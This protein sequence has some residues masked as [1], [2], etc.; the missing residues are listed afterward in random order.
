MAVPN[1]ALR[2]DAVRNRDLL[3]AAAEQEFAE[4]G[5]DAS[6]ADITARAEL[7]K[8]TFFRHF[9]TKEDLIAAIV[10]GH[11][12]AL[13]AVGQRLLAAP[14]AGEALLEF[15]TEAADQRQQREVAFLIRASESNPTMSEL[16]EAFFAT[17]NAL[18][19][20]AQ[21]ARAVRDDITGTDVVLLMCAPSSIVEHMPGAAP[22]LW[23]RYLAM[24]FDGLRPEGAHPLPS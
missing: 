19:T 16:R 14:D 10:R 21:A 7:G 15:L 13:D 12:H 8:G 17:V 24:I 23:K 6:V 1:R 4:H 9:A 11:V 22:D 18:V 3:L 5:L 2:A 20:R